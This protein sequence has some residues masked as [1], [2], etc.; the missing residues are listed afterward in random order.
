MSVAGICKLILGM[1]G[2]VEGREGEAWDRDT[3]QAYIEIDEARSDP[4]QVVSPI[5]SAE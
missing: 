3:L 5:T 4:G 2:G 1:M